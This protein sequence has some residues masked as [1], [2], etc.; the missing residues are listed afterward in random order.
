MR[1]NNKEMSKIDLFILE[2]M[3]VPREDQA[4]LQ[5][6]L[7]VDNVGPSFVHCQ[8]IYIISSTINSKATPLPK[9]NYAYIKNCHTLPLTISP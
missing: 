5:M 9:R 6:I 3:K 4:L 8:P 2:A 1:I 7:D